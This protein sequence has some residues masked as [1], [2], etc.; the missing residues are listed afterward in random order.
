MKM[1]PM[2][3]EMFLAATGRTDVHDEAVSAV[4]SLVK[5]PTKTRHLWQHLCVNCWSD[6]NWVVAVGYCNVCLKKVNMYFSPCS[7]LDCD[8][9]WSCRWIRRFGGTIYLHLQSQIEDG[10]RL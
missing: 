10:V 1:H 8:C 4:R 3:A 5:A 7:S 9:M 2:G 6:I